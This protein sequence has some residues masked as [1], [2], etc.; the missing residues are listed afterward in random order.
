MFVDVRSGPADGVFEQDHAPDPANPSHDVVQK[1]ARILHTSRASYGR[2]K[3]SNNG[4]E[5]RKDDRLTAVTLVKFVRTRQVVFLEKPRILTAEQ[6]RASLATDEVA[7]LVTG[8]CTERDQRKQPR[9]LQFSSSG[10]NSGSDQQGVAGEKEPDKHSGLDEDND[11]DHERAAP[12]EQ[13][14]NVVQARQNF[15]QEF[16]HL[17]IS[18]IPRVL[19]TSRETLNTIAEMLPARDWMRVVLSYYKL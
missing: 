9:Q 15:L 8:N 14:A 17:P 1:I 10:E 18:D 4:N 3:G 12:I 13:A 2:A 16:D 6:G 19:K 7:Q 11:A 5:S